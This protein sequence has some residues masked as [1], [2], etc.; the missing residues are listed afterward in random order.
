MQKILIIQNKILH[1]R[2]P[3]YNL[4]SEYYEVTVLHSG[5]ASVN[6]NDLYKEIITNT[7]K[8]G[9]FYVQ[10]DVISEIKKNKYDIFLVMFDIRWIKNILGFYFFQKRRRWIWWGLD[11]GKTRV[12]DWLKCIVCRGPAPIVFY[13]E[14]VKNIFIKKGLEQK[15]LF[16]ANNTF[17][18]EE[19]KKCYQSAIKDTLLFVGSLDFR[20]KN[21]TLIRVFSNI[22]DKIPKR[23]SLTVIG[24][25]SQKKH[26][27]DLARNLNISHKVIFLGKIND[28][29][30][31]LNYYKKAIVSISYGQAGLSVLQSFAYGV[32][33]VTKKNAIT[34]GERGN[35]V[36]GVN[37]IL[38]G[39]NESVFED[40]LLKLC[41]GQI[42][43]RQMGENAYEYYS[44]HCTLRCMVD[45]LVKAVES[46]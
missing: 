25:G 8:V 11:T 5:A 12:A 3:V 44:R 29:A 31:L 14:S 32:P 38:C 41:T 30:E 20:K 21:D 27:I 1:Y 7:L 23:I 34:G 16:V 4:L 22:V 18:V 33:F 13:S 10:K 40:T 42:N 9:P 35:I 39:D 36:D 2:K 45:G 37:G 43:Y 17:H 28:T 46:R 19:R 15:K 26:L 6:E 24:E